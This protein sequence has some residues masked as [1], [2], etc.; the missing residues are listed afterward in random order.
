MRM[1]FSCKAY[2]VAGRSDTEKNNEEERE[3]SESRGQVTTIYK[4]MIKETPL[5]SEQRPERTE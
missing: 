2:A 1:A 3:S 4:N 5:A